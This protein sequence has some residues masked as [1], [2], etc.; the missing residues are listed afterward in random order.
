MN[1]SLKIRVIVSFLVILVSFFYGLP[2]IIMTNKLGPDYNP[3]VISQKSP[4]ARDEAFAY[5]PF[6]NYILEG[7]LFLRDAYVVEYA[8]Y[9]TPFLGET[10]PSLIFAALA[11]LTGSVEK[12]F[13]AADF[14][15]PPIIFLLFYILIS[16][17]I[18]HKLFAVSVAFLTVIARDFIAIIPYPHETFQY[19]TFAEGQNYLLYFSRAFH[20]QMTFIFF[21]IA[22]ILLIKTLKVP[23]SKPTVLFFGLIFGLLF[24]SYVFYWT[25]ILLAVSFAF[26]HSLVRKNF[27]IVRSLTVSG[28]IASLLGSFYFYNPW[29]FSQLTI[30]DDFI[31]K[32]SLHSLSLPPTLFRYLIVTFLFATIVKLRSHESRVLFFVLLAGISISPL[33]RFIIGQDLETFHYLRRALMPLATIALFVTIY[34]LLRSRKTLILLSSLF[35]FFIF[36]FLGLRTQVIATEKI[37]SAHQRNRSQ[38][39]VFNWLV[40][41][42]PKGSTVGSLDTT[43]SSL[44]PV[45][46][47]NYVYFPPTD[48]TIMPT[49]EGVE[50]YATLANLLGIDVTWQKDNLDNILSY[51]FVYQA[52]NDL[53][54]LDLNS[55]KRHQAEAQIDKIARNNI[56]K[57]IE[58]FKLDYVVVTPDHLSIVH[59]NLKFTKPLTSID[60]FV[61]FQVDYK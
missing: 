8:N 61:I 5:A 11:K 14:I 36:L 17:F 33:S 37:L 20:P 4:I 47:K 51:L 24:Y 34:Y 7:K 39:A 25:Y 21:T 10:V 1:K 31:R 9:P 56:E 15:F 58:K 32:T 44:L 45:Y 13:I 2:N 30:A 19:L 16:F 53:N 57:E 48:R 3:L 35:I 52:Y 27:Q 29:Q 49:A 22:V 42:T 18:K 60:E 40:T 38:E 26:L 23:T 28:L 6:V 41:N 43:F 54:N 46:T 50:R 59:P 12:A 55:P